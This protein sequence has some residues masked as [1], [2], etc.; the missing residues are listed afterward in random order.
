LCTA[1]SQSI[2]NQGRLASFLIAPLSKLNTE[3]RAVYKRL[4]VC[5]MPPHMDWCNAVAGNDSRQRV[6]IAK[7]KTNT[8]SLETISSYASFVLFIREEGKRFALSSSV[9]RVALSPRPAQLMKYVS[10]RNPELGPLG[11]TFFEAN[12]RGC[13]IFFDTP[14]PKG[15]DSFLASTCDA[16][17]RQTDSQSTSV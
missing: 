16:G 5:Q 13:S 3:N 14:L 2:R 10:I 7:H 12:V 17:F 9:R 11:E 8:G 6:K 15:R 1:G 4:A